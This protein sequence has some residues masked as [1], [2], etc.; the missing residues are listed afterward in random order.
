MWRI[1]F[2]RSARLAFDAHCVIGP[3]RT[4]K[5]LKH[6]VRATMATMESLPLMRIS[7]FELTFE[8]TFE[9]RRR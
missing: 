7:L 3:N 6:V 4:M 5:R 2:K 8:A 9:T 1:C